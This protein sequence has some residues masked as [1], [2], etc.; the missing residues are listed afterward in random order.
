MTSA[1]TAFDP[2]QCPSTLRALSRLPVLL[3]RFVRWRAGR[4]GWLPRHLAR[5]R[6]FDRKRV[7]PDGPIDVMVL[8]SD[9]FEPARRDGDRAAAESVRSW[10]RTYEQIAGGVCDSD[11][12]PPQHTWFYRMDYPNP[13]CLQALCES[14]F[15]GF[16]EV[17]F[18]LHHGHDTHDSFLGRLREGLR[19]AGEYGAM[20]TAEARPQHRFGYVA[21]NS[22][23][24]NGAGDDALSG[25]P[26]ELAA[27]REAGCYADFTFPALG[28]P[29]QP[30]LTNALY[31]ATEDGA[32]R[33]QA[34]GTPVEVGRPASGDLMIFQGPTVFN[35]GDGYVD[36]ASVENSSPPH[37]RRLAPWLAGHVHVLGRPEWVFVKISTHAMQNRAAFLGPAMPALLEAM[38]AWWARPPFRL[39]FVTAREAFNIVKAAEAGKAG[40]AGDFRDFAIPRPANRVASCAAPWRLLTCTPAR[41]VVRLREPG[42]ARLDLA[43]G[44]LR[45]VEGFLAEVEAHA[46]QGE[47]A[48]LRLQGQ[49]PIEVT[50]RD[51]SRR[52]LPAGWWLPGRGGGGE[53][54]FHE[55][56]SFPVRGL[57][58]QRPT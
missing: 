10:C 41:F 5:H 36:D 22:A 20:L 19:W 49:G 2:E 4:G 23:L 55:S 32:P 54:T 50:L 27:L 57:T 35:W 25:C 40:N 29:S 18:H 30:A 28:S 53:E 58:T 38:C 31:Y 12:V 56:G 48:A 8:V 6:R 51:G 7:A 37:P 13:G 17:E 24:D 45:R 1:P 11:G 9:H 15:R 39:H 46:S 21:G 33:S 43:W 52:T 14:T 44:P 47:L 3:Y 26:T 16:G 42:P 34:R